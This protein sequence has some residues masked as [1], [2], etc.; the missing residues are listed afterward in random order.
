[1]PQGYGVP[2]TPGLNGSIPTITAPRSPGLKGEPGAASSNRYKATEILSPARPAGRNR[3]EEFESDGITREEARTLCQ[4]FDVPAA[5]IGKALEKFDN[6]EGPFNY[7]EFV[8]AIGPIIVPNVGVST[9]FHAEAD[10]GPRWDTIT[11]NFIEDA[12][13]RVPLGAVRGR[14]PIQNHHLG[15]QSPWLRKMDQITPWL[16]DTMGHYPKGGTWPPP[17]LKWN[18]ASHCVKSMLAEGEPRPETADGPAEAR[19]P[20]LARYNLTMATSY[21]SPRRKK[22]SSAPSSDNPPRV[23]FEG[24]RSRTVP[25]NHPDRVRLFEAPCVEK[26][27]AWFESKGIPE[28]GAVR[29]AGFNTEKPGMYLYETSDSHQ[30]FTEHCA[31]ETPSFRKH[32]ARDRHKHKPLQDKF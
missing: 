19:C 2:R 16:T 25:K 29:W 23:F 13:H 11:S 21:R 6:V 31:K 3:S 26:G 27:A 32:I 1:M 28:P 18:P 9:S 20:T 24:Q 8:K 30:H 12:K 22:P 15:L 4:R 14:P 7:E 5:L 17:E 10:F